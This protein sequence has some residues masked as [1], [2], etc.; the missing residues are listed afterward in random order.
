VFQALSLLYLVRHQQ[1]G[2]TLSALRSALYAVDEARIGDL[3][4]R[5][6]TRLLS[7]KL[8][9]GL[10]FF[11]NTVIAQP[12]LVPVAAGETQ[13]QRRTTLLSGWYSFN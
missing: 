5:M 4:Y 8:V 2:Y 7:T 11:H 13:Q 1:S 10:Y 3:Y 6:N 12:S 9:V